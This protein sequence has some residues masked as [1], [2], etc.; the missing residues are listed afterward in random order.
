MQRQG[1]QNR[2]NV[3]RLLSIDNTKNDH[4]YNLLRQHI[5]NQYHIN[6]NVLILFCCIK[7]FIRLRYNF[8]VLFQTAQI[9]Y[10]HLDAHTF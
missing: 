3:S 4:I 1:W 5:V 8:A 6:C 7:C 9:K 2:L 10:L